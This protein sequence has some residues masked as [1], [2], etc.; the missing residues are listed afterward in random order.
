MQSLGFV[1]S[2][3]AILTVPSTYIS[4]NNCVRRVRNRMR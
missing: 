3:G 2:E 4:V 1:L